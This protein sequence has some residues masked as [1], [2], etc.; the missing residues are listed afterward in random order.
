MTSKGS[1]RVT[2]RLTRVVSTVVFVRMTQ[3]GNSGTATL[4]YRSTLG[5]G[6]KVEYS[7]IGNGGPKIR[8]VC[9]ACRAEALNAE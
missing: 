3:N 2:R 6:H 9:P 1:S 5:C 4:W 8:A 7:S